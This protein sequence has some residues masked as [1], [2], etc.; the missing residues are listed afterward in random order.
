MSPNYLT[1]PDEGLHL[2][3]NIHSVIREVH[4]WNPNRLMFRALDSANEKAWNVLGYSA[5][6]IDQLDKA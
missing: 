3:I 4:P 5:S 1:V 6:G 2:L